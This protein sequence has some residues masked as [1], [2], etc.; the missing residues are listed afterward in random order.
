M[1]DIVQ[2][3]VSNDNPTEDHNF[4]E[5]GTVPNNPM[6]H[7]EDIDESNNVMPP[8]EKKY[9]QRLRKKPD[10]YDAC[11]TD[12]V[13]RVSLSHIDQCLYPRFMMLQ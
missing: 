1:D 4:L 2:D 7:K 10:Y 8:N 9:P 11:N 12:S 6:K 5:E 3:G 13:Y